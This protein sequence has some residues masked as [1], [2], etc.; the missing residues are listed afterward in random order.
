MMYR[1]GIHYYLPLKFLVALG[2]LDKDYVEREQVEEVL[3][4]FITTSCDGFFPNITT[5]VVVYG[6]RYL[7]MCLWNRLQISGLFSLH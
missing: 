3:K 1:H 6:Y 7:V 4:W 2:C 5:F